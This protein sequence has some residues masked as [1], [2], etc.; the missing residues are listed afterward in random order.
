MSW[1]KVGSGK[2][3][4]AL[5]LG[6]L[7]ENRS[8][9]SLQGHHSQSTGCPLAFGS[10][11]WNWP[12]SPLYLQLDE[13]TDVLQCSRL[14]VFFSFTYSIKDVLFCK[15][16]CK[17]SLVIHIS[18]IMNSFFAKQIF[19]YGGGNGTWRKR[20]PSLLGNTFMLRGTI[21]LPLTAFPPE[22]IK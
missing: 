7:G 10:W 12:L 14:L 6:A 9:P 19:S 20:T 21:S 22:P 15:S 2:R 13:T 16:Y 5:G 18:K 4:S 11:S 17:T 1:L 3:G 8:C